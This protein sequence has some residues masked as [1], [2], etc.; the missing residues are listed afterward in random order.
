MTLPKYRAGNGRPG[1]LR[2]RP[3]ADRYLHRQQ[4]RFDDFQEFWKRENS[5]SAATRRRD[6]FQDAVLLQ[7]RQ[8]T[9]SGRYWYTR[10]FRKTRAREDWLLE[11]PI[12]CPGCMTGSG[13]IVN[14]TLQVVVEIENVLG[15]RQ[16]VIGLVLYRFEEE[17][18]P[19]G[20]VIVSGDSKRQ[21]AAFRSRYPGW[22][23]SRR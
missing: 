17:D 1:Q 19:A 4:L 10:P 2:S 8:D 14:A 11:Y 20:P 5:R 3:L 23:R 22:L 16:V 21:Q 13:G 9:A 15:F 7:I 12:Q 18:A 6:M